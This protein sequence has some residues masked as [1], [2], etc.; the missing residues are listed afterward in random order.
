MANSE[1]RQNSFLFTRFR[2]TRWPL[3]KGGLN[4]KTFIVTT[5]LGALRTSTIDTM[6]RLALQYYTIPQSCPSNPAFEC[7]IFPKYKEVFAI[8]TFGIRI[9]VG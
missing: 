8:P 9:S 1:P 5:R 2:K 6:L 4:F 3:T 7:T